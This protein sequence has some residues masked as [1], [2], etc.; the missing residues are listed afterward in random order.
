MS[1]ADYKVLGKLYRCLDCR[2][3]FSELRVEYLCSNGHRLGEGSLAFEGVNAYKISPEK[4]A[5]LEYA[6][7]DVEEL[8]RLLREEGLVAEGP[9]M[10][11]GRSGV[12]HEFSFVVWDEARAISEGRRSPLVVGSVHA[13][14]KVKASDVLVLYA[15]SFDVGAEHKLILAR[16]VADK[17]VREL[18]KIYGIDVLESRDPKELMER[19]KEH[20]LEAVRS[21]RSRGQ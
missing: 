18:A 3:M 12:L 7:L 19:A 4:R 15:K 11:A 10:V 20:V 6:M 9:V 5:L 16:G 17:E 14:D 1:E 13:S 21:A 8:V 2:R